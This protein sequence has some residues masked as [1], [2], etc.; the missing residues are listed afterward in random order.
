V[1]YRRRSL[2]LRIFEPFRADIP[3]QKNARAGVVV[4]Q[5]SSS[6]VA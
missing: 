4:A 1:R 3:W 6:F 5:P 2:I